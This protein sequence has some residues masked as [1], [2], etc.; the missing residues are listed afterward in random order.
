MVFKCFDILENSMEPPSQT[1]PALKPAISNARGRPWSILYGV[2]FL[3][4][5]SFIYFWSCRCCCCKED[6]LMLYFEHS[7]MDCDGGRCFSAQK[8]QQVI[9]RLWCQ[10]LR[11]KERDLNHFAPMLNNHTGRNPSAE[12]E[13]PISL[14]TSTDLTPSQCNSATKHV[15]LW[16]KVCDPKFFFRWRLSVCYCTWLPLLPLSLSPPSMHLNPMFRRHSEEYKK[17]LSEIET[18][19]ADWRNVGTPK[20]WIKTTHHKIIPGMQ[21][22]W[23]SDDTYI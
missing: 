17:L 20:K 12:A 1:L 7:D 3:F 11:I 23:H 9:V 2:V 22:T 16:A 5:D 6:K 15:A 21:W 13:I 14:L 18:D 10:L 19:E 4:I 8:H